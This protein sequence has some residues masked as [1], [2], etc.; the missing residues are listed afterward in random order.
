MSFETAENHGKLFTAI[1]SLVLDDVIPNPEKVWSPLASRLNVKFATPICK[2]QL[3]RIARRL[4]TYFGKDGSG[5][6]CVEN[7]NDWRTDM[8]ESDVVDEIVIGY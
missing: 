1:M 7:I 8:D 4:D 6:V 2:E 5:Y 3:Y